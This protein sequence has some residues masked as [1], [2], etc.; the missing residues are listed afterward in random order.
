M[1]D[2]KNEAPFVTHMSHPSS[3]HHALQ[4][5]ELAV[6]LKYILVSSLIITTAP[7]NALL[8]LFSSSTKRALGIY[9]EKSSS[10]DSVSLTQLSKRSADLSVSFPSR[11]S[12]SLLRQMNSRSYSCAG[13][14]HSRPHMATCVTCLSFS[15]SRW[16]SC[17]ACTSSISPQRLIRR[18]C[19]SKSGAEASGLSRSRQAL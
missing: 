5:G 2:P 1:L 13:L 19:S 16:P 8:N 12:S 15:A 7:V 11:N 6:K 9:G 4:A 18:S 14:L 3:H 10:S 17:V